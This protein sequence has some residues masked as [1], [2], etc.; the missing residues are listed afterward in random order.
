M[1][2]ARDYAKYQY[3]YQILAGNEN[4]WAAYFGGDKSDADFY[5]GAYNRINSQYGSA[6][7]IDWQNE[8]FGKQAI[9]QNHNV[10]LSSGTD[11]TRFLISYNNTGQNGILD[12]HDYQKNGLRF[13]LNHEIMKGLR[14]DFNAYLNNKRDTGGGSLGG[15]LKMRV[16]QP[17]TGGV[18]Y[19][20]DQLLLSDMSDDMQAI[21]SQYDI[22][23]PIIT[24]DAVT[25]KAITRQV[26]ANAG[27]ELDITKD[28]MFRTADCY[29]WTQG[30]G[31]YWDDGSTK[32]AETNGGPYGYRNNREKYS[33]QV[34]NTLNWGRKFSDHD[35]K[36]L[37]GQEALYSENISL[38][39]TYLGFP[40]VNF[41]LDN[42]QMAANVTRNSG[43]SYL[44]L[45]SFFSRGSYN[46]KGKYIANFTL[47]A[48][49]SSMF[50]EG[51]KWDYFPS[52]S[53]AWRISDENFMQTQ[54][55]VSNLK[56]RLG[57]GSS[58]NNSI[59]HNA[60]ATN[61]GSGSYSINSLNYPTLVP[62]SML[63]NPLIRWE[64]IESSNLGLDADFLKGRISLSIDAYNNK[65]EDLLIENRIPPSTGYS[66]Q[67]QNIGSLRNRGVDA[68]LKT[69]NISSRKFHWSTNF[70]IGFNR[71]KILSIYGNSEDDYF[72]N[73]YDSRIDFMFKV[74]EPLGQFYGYKYDGV[75]TTDDFIQNANGTYSLKPG[76]PR[77][78]GGNVANIK[79][80]DVKYLPTAGETDANGNP[81]WSTKDRTV[82]GSGLPKFQGGIGNTLNYK[83]FDLTVFVNFSAGNKIFNMNTQRFIGPY[84]PNQNQLDVTNTRFT[85]I[86]P[87]TGRE[88]TDLARL[89]ELNPQKYNKKALWSLHSTNSI[90]IS[91]ALDY[92][93]EDASYLRI[94]T[95]TLGYALP[96]ALSSKVRLK[97]ARIYGTVNNLHTFTK[98]KGFDPEV[99]SANVYD[100][101]GNTNSVMFPGVDNSA[102]P[103]AKTFVF[104]L[105]VTF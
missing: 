53:V 64:R 81:V 13:K 32:T 63:G 92:Y 88:S 27:F 48:D 80:G 96:K 52:A 34:T 9:T 33:W 11:K 49:G 66:R 59:D 72:T 62:G 1:L 104:G 58:G 35:V 42:V 23:N 19:T 12:K 54:N 68:V 25:N 89:A 38:N 79:P 73:S 17:A 93:L 78:K 45:V 6:E 40:P 46:Y 67:T 91:D 86:D 22:Y 102:Y 105:N 36:V 99:S 2:N 69:T 71:S 18:R 84:L 83:N 3:E 100:A 15:P 20:K 98:Y 75:Y 61:Y 87:Q 97:N 5:T 103:R 43:K 8:V 10:N 76:V 24:N 29:T 94:G 57:Y 30:R 4:L 60:Y 41:G 82:I 77:L 39:N 26:V 31:V 85:L 7:T 50:M 90:T 55:L 65:S 95:V 16:L 101:D 37:M 51:R 47:R 70:N 28:I 21:N 14:S 74:G 44:S 56:L